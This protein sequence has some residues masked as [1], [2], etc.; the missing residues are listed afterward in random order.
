MPPLSPTLVTLLWQGSLVLFCALE[1]SLQVCCVDSFA[2]RR[3][4]SRS[5]CPLP[6]A[7]AF[8]MV[9]LRLFSTLLSLFSAFLFVSWSSSVFAIFLIWKSSTEWFLVSL[10]CVERML[11]T[12]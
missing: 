11:H 7:L 10:G 3:S 1:E 5:S 6:F 12:G 8:S 4:P 2:Q 9:P